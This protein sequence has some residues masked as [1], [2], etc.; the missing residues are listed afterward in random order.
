MR[1]PL[2]YCVEQADHPDLDP[3]DLVVSA[4]PTPSVSFEPDL[5]GGVT[6]LI[7][8]A[9]A[10]APEPAWENRL[11]RTVS[12]HPEDLRAEAVELKAVPYY[13]WANREPGA[14]HVWLRSL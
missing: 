6:A 14:M 5:L 2:L 11:Y 9:E 4:G 8:R 13:A 3:R 1:G 7:V 12:D 10:V